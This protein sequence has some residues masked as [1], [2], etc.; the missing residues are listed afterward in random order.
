MLIEDVLEFMMDGKW[1]V[2]SE[3]GDVMH[4]PV[5]LIQKSIDFYAKF[6]F[7]EFDKKRKMA[8][9]TPEIKDLFLSTS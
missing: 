2:I 9:V 4:K 3:I 6:G 7:L 5:A 1:H 8:I